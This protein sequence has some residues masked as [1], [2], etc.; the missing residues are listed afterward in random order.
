MVD[1]QSGPVIVQT[2]SKVRLVEPEVCEELRQP[3]FYLK[4]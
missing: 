4:S 2:G 1:Y 3:F